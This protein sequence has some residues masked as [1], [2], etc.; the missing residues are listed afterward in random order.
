MKHSVYGPLL[1]KQVHCTRAVSQG[2]QH[3]QTAPLYVGA[4]DELSTHIN[5]Q[6][7][8]SSWL[9]SLSESVLHAVRF[10]AEQ[11]W[12][13]TLTFAGPTTLAT[14]YPVRRHGARSR[15]LVVLVRVSKITCEVISRWLSLRAGQSKVK[16]NGKYINQ[17]ISTRKSKAS[18]DQKVIVL[19]MMVYGR[20]CHKE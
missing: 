4:A 13:T 14:G 16:K 6:H 17:D 11:T 2:G 18:I 8:I 20:W 1:T 7:W 5:K 12:W 15:V 19:H 9:S 10:T 3:L